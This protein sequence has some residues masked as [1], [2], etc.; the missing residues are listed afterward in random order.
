MLI[1]SKKRLRQA[2]NA[3]GG[4]WGYQSMIFFIDID[5]YRILYNLGI[6]Y[7]LYGNYI[8]LSIGPFVGIACRE[9]EQVCAYANRQ[10]DL[11]LDISAN[12]EHSSFRKA[13]RMAEGVPGVGDVRDPRWCVCGVA[14]RG[15]LCVYMYRYTHTCIVKRN[16]FIY[17]YIIFI[18]THICVYIYIQL[19]ALFFSL[20]LF[21]SV[22]MYIEREIHIYICVYVVSYL[23]L[24]LSLSLF[25]SLSVHLFLFHDRCSCRATFISF[26]VRCSTC[27]Y[28]RYVCMIIYIYICI[29][30]EREGERCI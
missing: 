14:R 5:R 22:H 25:L 26:Y 17:I 2:W 10:H 7:F 27:V 11:G 24:Y 23:F 18:C 30:I 6:R 21:L 29:C 3:V 15:F 19:T 1:L 12:P 28:I 16:I 9:T 13:M 20:S 4:A 8:A